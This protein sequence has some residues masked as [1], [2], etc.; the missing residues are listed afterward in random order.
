M[1]WYLMAAGQ[2]DADGNKHFLDL[3][4]KLKDSSRVQNGGK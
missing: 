2:G 1:R 3:A 4:K